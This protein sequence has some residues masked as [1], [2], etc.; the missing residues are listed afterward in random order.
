MPKFTYPIVFIY[1]QEEEKYNGFIP[2]LSI[3]AEGEKMEDVYASAEDLIHQYF[4]LALKHD[5]DFPAPSTLEEISSK[6]E[7]FKISLLTATIKD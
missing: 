7:G 6:W 1:N 5:L 2:D 4:G 3:F